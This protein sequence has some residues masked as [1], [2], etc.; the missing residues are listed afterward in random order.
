M[1]AIQARRKHNKTNNSS[2]HLSLVSINRG[3]F[4]GRP[5][6]MAVLRAYL[7]ASGSA[8]DPQIDVLSVS[9]FIAHEDQWARFEKLWPVT[10]KRFDIQE[11]S[12]A[13]F[14]QSF[15]EFAKWKDKSQE[16]VRREF[17][18]AITKVIDKHTMS[19]VGATVNLQAYK[20]FNERFQLEEVLGTPYGMAGMLAI[21]ATMD[22]KER[23]KITEPIVFYFEKGDNEQADFRKFI[24]DRIKYDE[25]D[26][27]VEPI[28]CKK[29][30]VDEDG[31]TRYCY[32][33]QASDFVAYEHAKT[34]VDLIRDGKIDMRMSARGIVPYTSDRHMWRGI[35][36]H[37]LWN[38]IK[39][40]GVPKRPGNTTSYEVP[41][42][43]LCY[44]GLDNPI[45]GTGGIFNN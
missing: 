5:S 37:T 29:R 24:R 4:S 28:F 40:F 38:T 41:E 25:P 13:A 36:R 32:P 17:I 2:N 11:L 42:G 8:L 20:W 16:P 3:C 33:F 39:N 6:L 22:W 30:W 12:M 9:G 45:P 15:G 26:Y 7:D 23:N 18:Q 31:F 1:R 19:P 14:A 44:L 27:M 21:S 43:P 34:L 35:N 10:L